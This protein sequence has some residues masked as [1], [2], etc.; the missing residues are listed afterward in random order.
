MAYL[1]PF[2]A[3]Q[4]ENLEIIR[5]DTNAHKIETTLVQATDEC[6]PMHLDQRGPL[7]IFHDQEPLDISY[8]AQLL[9]HITSNTRPP[10]VLVTTERN[11]IDGN[12]MCENYPFAR[13]DY[14]FHIFAATDWFRGHE[15]LPGL[16][17]PRDRTLKKTY[18][19]FNRLTSN[20]RIYRS[21]LVNELYKNNLLDSG[22]VSYSKTCPDGGS[23]DDNLRQGVPEYQLDP[24]LVEEAITNISQ[25]PDLRIDF[26]DHDHIP[27][28]SMLL[29]PLEQLMESFVFVVTETCFFQ[30]KTH[31]TEKIFKPIVLRMPFILVGCAY[32]L[33]YLRSYGF[34]TFGD[35]WDESYDTIEDPVLRLQAI[36]NILTKLDAMSKEDQMAMLLDMQPILEHNYNLFNDPAFVRS[37]WEYLKEELYKMCQLYKFKMPYR[38]NNRLGQAIPIDPNEP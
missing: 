15:Y 26:N 22:Y 38:L 30:T 31:L 9:D 2:G 5:D 4:P 6:T 32:N 35:F 12:A 1:Y 7:F 3:T 24:S 13:I 29:S 36:V 33:E 17:A 19:T 20:K 21:L 11:S 10:W 27:N 28:Q 14:F 18:I 8:N 16:I 23:Y 34:K 25:L 37:E